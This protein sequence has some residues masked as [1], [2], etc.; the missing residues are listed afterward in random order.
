MK[1]RCERHQSEGVDEG[2]VWWCIKVKA[3]KGCQMQGR[4][5]CIQS[6]SWRQEMLTGLLQWHKCQLVGT[7]CGLQCQGSPFLVCEDFSPTGFSC[8]YTHFWRH[9]APSLHY[10]CYCRKHF[11]TLIHYRIY[12]GW[13][14]WKHFPLPHTI[15][16]KLHMLK[17]HAVA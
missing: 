5:K 17:C 10:A 2:K 6:V 16:L 14:S 7:V 11:S 15:T 1:E 13:V 12:G 3:S 4:S 9:T 8:N